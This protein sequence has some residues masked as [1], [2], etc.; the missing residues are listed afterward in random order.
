MRQAAPAVHTPVLTAAAGQELV[1]LPAHLLP[2]AVEVL[3]M[4]FGMSVMTEE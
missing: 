1:V 2:A 3:L 4:R